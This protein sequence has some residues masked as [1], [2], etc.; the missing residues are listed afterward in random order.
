MTGSV[1]MGGRFG[2]HVGQGGYAHAQVA[3]LR[4]VLGAL[5][6][7]SVAAQARDG[8]QQAQ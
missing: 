3:E 7:P 8:P 4:P 2:A 5:A 6:A 1:A